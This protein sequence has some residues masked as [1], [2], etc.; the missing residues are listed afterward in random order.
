MPFDI[1][2]WERHWNRRKCG[3]CPWDNVPALPWRERP[4]P[5]SGSTSYVRG[6][7]QRGARRTRPL[8]SQQNVQHGGN[9]MADAIFSMEEQL[10]SLE[11]NFANWDNYR[12]AF[13]RSKPE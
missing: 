6:S 10:E 4:N 1:G 12:A 7:M 2:D 13:A 5:R 9:N 11:R 8:I 3:L